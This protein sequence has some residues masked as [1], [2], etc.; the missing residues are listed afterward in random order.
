MFKKNTK[1]LILVLLQRTQLSIF[2]SSNG[3]VTNLA[4]P[5]AVVQDLEIKD[6][7][8]FVTLLRSFITSQKLSNS[9]V[10]MILDKSVYFTKLVEEKEKKT[11]TDEKKPEAVKDTTEAKKSTE[12][13]EQKDKVA[14][15]EELSEAENQRKIFVQSMPF[16]NIYSHVVII[17]KT[18]TIIALNRELYEPIVKTFN[19]AGLEVTYIYPILVVADIFAEKGFNQ[20]TAGHLLENRIKYKSQN[21]LHSAEKKIDDFKT[22]LP[23]EEKGKKRVLLLVVVFMLLL[24]ALAGVWWLSQK[25]QSN[26][27]I[28]RQ[29][30]AQP[31]AAG[32]VATTPEPTTTPT[33][34]PMP[35]TLE[36]MLE[37]T[38]S[39][40]LSVSLINASGATAPATTL[41]EQLT[42]VGFSDVSIEE[43]VSQQAGA[44]NISVSPDV[45]IALREALLA[46]LQDWG[47]TTTFE[48]AENQS[49]AIVITV[50]KQ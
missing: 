9:E 1:E 16:N 34:T 39:A 35:A 17:G 25:N 5:P 32:S 29:G 33:P 4:F 46:Q 43:T 7:S 44:M 41:E 8:A 10:V 13:E 19:E 11:E 31:A 12:N 50:T 22:V 37:S 23:K 49:T 42:E 2:R 36:E 3:A 24:A 30:P 14:D 6:E 21:F 40:E 47:Y 26:D 45:A 27:G 20:Q 38:V 15:P 48:E 18:K 28:Q